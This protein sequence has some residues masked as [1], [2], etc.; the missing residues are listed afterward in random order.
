MNY[1]VKL[2]GLSIATPE[3]PAEIKIESL[4]VEV[5]NLDLKDVAGLVSKIPELIRGVRE[6]VECELQKTSG[7]F[8]EN[9]DRS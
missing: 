4:E 9:D 1:R 7:S 2:T 5:Q 3:L 8:G 6:A